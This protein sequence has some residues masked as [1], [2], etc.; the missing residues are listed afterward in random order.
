VS[1]ADDEVV[2]G[3]WLSP[4]V[5]AARLRDPDYPFVPDTRALLARFGILRDPGPH[6]SRPSPA[7]TG[8]CSAWE[9]A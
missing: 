9:V 2:S 4:G 1:F 5:L 8:S 6:R 7:S 3:E